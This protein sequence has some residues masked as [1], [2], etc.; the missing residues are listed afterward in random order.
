MRDR[1]GIIT[2][3]ERALWSNVLL[4]AVFDAL[5]GPEG[6]PNPTIRARKTNK[7][8]N[9]ITTPSSDLYFVCT[10][11]GIEMNALIERMQRH[12]AEAPTSEELAEARK[13][14]CNSLLKRGGDTQKSKCSNITYTLNGETLSVPQW[15]A[16][17]GVKP[18]TIRN[19]I[20]NGWS[21]E[22]ALTL[23]IDEAQ[24]RARQSMRTRIN[25]EARTWNAGTPAKVLDP[26][27][28]A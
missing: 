20:R 1:Q 16:R 26:N 5:I 6:E 19:R 18:Q 28:R 10:C 23:T 24:H 9:Y 17:I 22:D 14:H 4:I 7:A 3:S 11:A 21:I 15:A 27:G 13:A 2:S 25:S 12:L 8:R